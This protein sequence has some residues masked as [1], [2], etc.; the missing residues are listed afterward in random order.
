MA[1]PP[2]STVKSSLGSGVCARV[3]TCSAFRFHCLL[4]QP[5]QATIPSNPLPFAMAFFF[6]LF[7]SQVFAPHALAHNA[8]VG[9]RCQRVHE[10]RLCSTTRGHAIRSPLLFNRSPGVCLCVCVSVCLC[11][12]VRVR[13]CVRACLCFHVCVCVSVSARLLGL[14]ACRVFTPSSFPFLLR[15]TRLVFRCACMQFGLRAHTLLC[16]DSATCGCCTQRQC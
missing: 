6:C 8:G 3:S 15:A 2:S 16:S 1:N 14:S 7:S 12:C 4:W 10:H 11:A 13:V 5:L 9:V